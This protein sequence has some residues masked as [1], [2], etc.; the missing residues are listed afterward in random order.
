MRASPFHF[1]VSGL[2]ALT[3]L[4]A[5][6]DLPSMMTFGGGYDDE[7]AADEGDENKCNN[8]EVQCIQELLF[9]KSV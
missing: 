7:Y 2:K 3:L 6:L 4:P 5:S 1:H 9:G 8:G